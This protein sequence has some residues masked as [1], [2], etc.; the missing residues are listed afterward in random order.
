M[1][2]LDRWM[3]A[4]TGL[5]IGAFFAALFLPYKVASSLETVLALLTV[6]TVVFAGAASIRRRHPG[7]ECFALAWGASLAGVVTQARHNHGLLPSNPFTANGLLVGLTL[8]MVLST[9]ALADSIKF[10][11]RDAALAQARMISEQAMVQALQQ[12]RERY[13]AVIDHGAEGM[14]V[15]QDGR[16]AFVNFRATEMLEASKE[17]IVA[18]GVGARV[19]AEDRALMPSACGAGWL[20]WNCR[21]VG[22]CG[23]NGPA[24]R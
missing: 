20:A 21:S 1:P 18:Q 23:C 17:K 5:W 7:A 16:I 24:N 2:A 19:Q 15:V 10:A 13:R 14:V 22:R 3:L 11:R 9:F 4:L 12:S 6:V 8:E